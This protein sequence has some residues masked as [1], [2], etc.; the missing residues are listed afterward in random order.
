MNKKA[1]QKI[2]AALWFLPDKIYLNLYYSLLHKKCINWNNPETFNEKLQWLKIYNQDE[3]HIHI[4]DK[5]EVKPI[6]ASLIGEEYIIRTL[7]VWNSFDELNFDMLPNRFVLKCTHDS[8]GIVICRDKAT[9]DRKRAKKFIES[10]LKH[11]YFY[12]GR[13][14]PYKHVQP[15]IIAEEYL[16]NETGEEN[17]NDYKF[18][19]FDGEV[20]CSFV[21]T[22]R[23]SKDG[24]KV[25]FYDRKWDK[26]PLE[27]KYLASKKEIEKPKNYDLMIALAEKLSK[28]FSFVRIDL[29]EVNGKVYFGEYTLYPGNGME[30]FRPDEWDKKMGSWIKLPKRL[31]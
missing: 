22:D 26:M 17:I 16:E 28:G 25:T 20:K 7:G 18:M 8:G 9:F 13:E 27:R 1:I 12:I 3:R 29:Y 24:L 19:C 5:F 23:Q 31:I 11:N 15:R 21:C 2:K 6:V 4:V 30:R 10:C 14:W